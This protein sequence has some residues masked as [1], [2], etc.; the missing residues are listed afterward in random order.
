[1]RLSP[2]GYG[3]RPAFLNVQDKTRT[4]SKRKK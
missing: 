1:V 2:K 4:S 3:K